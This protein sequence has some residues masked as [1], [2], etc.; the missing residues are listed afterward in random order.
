MLSNEQLSFSLGKTMCKELNFTSL[1]LMIM[2]DSSDSS[3]SES[4]SL[5]ES[6]DRD[7]EQI[8]CNFRDIRESEDFIGFSRFSFCIILF[9]HEGFGIGDEFR[10]M[11]NVFFLEGFSSFIFSWIND[12]M[13]DFWS[14]SSFWFFLL[15]EV[16]EL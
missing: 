6:A 12:E 9:R 1:G 16:Y 2:E 15:Y 7:W 4:Y 14:F 8:D 10:S 11:S 13:Y 5:Q 3:L